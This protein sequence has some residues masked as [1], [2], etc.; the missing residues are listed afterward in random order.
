M[1]KP[2]K[3]YI[4]RDAP[5]GSVSQWFGENRDLYFSRMKME[6]HNGIDIV[7]PHGTPIYAVEGGI[8]A[9]VKNSPDG[10]GKHLRIITETGR[11]WTYGHAHE[12]LVN[13]GDKVNEGDKIQ[14]MGNT[15][16]VVSSTDGNGFWRLG[17]NKWAGTHLHLGLRNVKVS[18]TKKSGYWQYNPNT[19]FIKV[20][21]YNNGYFGSVNFANLLTSEPIIIEPFK[22][23]LKFGDKGSEVNRLQEELKKLGFFK[24]ETSEY[25]GERTLLA[26]NAFQKKY[27]EEILTPIGLKY[28]TGYF[29]KKTREKLNEILNQ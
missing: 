3:D 16:F 12:N 21:D 6:G 9:D 11:E 5:R 17:S 14:L 27:K 24:G 1:Q 10:Y 25:F 26:V 15:G 4:H 7:A 2:I 20:L 19:P 28:P 8:V 23:D 18:K 29:G 13:I 22:E